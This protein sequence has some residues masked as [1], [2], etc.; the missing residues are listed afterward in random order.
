[1]D[2]LGIDH[3][4]TFPQLHG[5]LQEQLLKCGPIQL[6]VEEP[7]IAMENQAVPDPQ[8]EVPTASLVDQAGVQE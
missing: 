6:P 7:A 4:R 8:E 3:D 1:M 5:D 2:L